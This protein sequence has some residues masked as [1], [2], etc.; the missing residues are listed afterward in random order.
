MS[1]RRD[2]YRPPV[3]ELGGRAAAV[4]AKND[5]GLAAARVFTVERVGTVHQPDHVG[6]PLRSARLR[7]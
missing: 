1:A 7:Y 6:I 4:L 5:V 3:T 2:N